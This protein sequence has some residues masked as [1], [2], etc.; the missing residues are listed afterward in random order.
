M[1]FGKKRTLRGQ[2]TVVGGVARSNLI[3]ADGL[4]NYGLRIN[5]FI[6]WP[7]NGYTGGSDGTFTAI[8]SLD[9]ISSGANMNAGDNR[10]FAWTFNSV[11]G[12]PTP[13][14]VQQLREI[15]DPDHIVNRD[16]F[17]TMDNSTDGIYNFLIE[18]QVIELTDDE[19]IITIIKET[20]QT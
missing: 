4:V 11:R 2:V 14:L 8:L 9:T 5:R 12:V 15:I 16:L 19:A 7:E 1:K 13:S 3:V 17:L 10:Q 20:S 6:V 18:C